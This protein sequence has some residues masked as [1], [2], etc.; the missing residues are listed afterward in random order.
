VG[1]VELGIESYKVLIPSVAG[2][3]DV[4]PAVAVEMIP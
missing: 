4:T 2:A 3:A 1:G